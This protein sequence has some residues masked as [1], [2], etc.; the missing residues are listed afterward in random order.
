MMR[1]TLAAIGIALGVSVSV[2]FVA[3]PA[4]AATNDAIAQAL[5]GATL[6]NLGLDN[7][8]GELSQQLTGQL[9]EAIE[10]GVIDPAISAQV[11]SLM[12]NPALI[13]GLADVFEA[14]LRGQTTTWRDSALSTSDPVR[15][16]ESERDEG[17]PA[18]DESPG[19]GLNSGNGNG[20]GN[21]N[22]SD[23]DENE[24]GSG[25]SNGNSGNGN[26]GN[27]NGGNGGNG[28]NGNGN[29]GNGGN[30]NNGNGNNG[31]GNNGNGNNGNGNNGNGNNG[32]GKGDG[33]DD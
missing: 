1:K 4:S 27:G 7:I 31:N 30:G 17:R 20:N 12:E 29:N 15:A 33:E 23:E 16:P 6:Q 18:R 32:N 8:S 5:V 9:T 3:Q 25:P 21:G 2:S 14:H 11:A 19:P 22:G 28:N 26:N 13:S 10:A 24:D